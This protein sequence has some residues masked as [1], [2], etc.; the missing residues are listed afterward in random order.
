M[1]LVWNAVI[2]TC[3]HR[4]PFKIISCEMDIRVV[5]FGNDVL[6]YNIPL[7]LLTFSKVSWVKPPSKCWSSYVGRALRTSPP[8]LRRLRIVVW[9]GW[10]CRWWH[11][12]TDSEWRMHRVGW[13]SQST[14]GWNSFH[15]NPV[16]HQSKR[17]KLFFFF[18][19]SFYKAW[20]IGV[21]T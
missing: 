10:S 1:S 9:D 14:F 21:Y 5:F 16:V 2:S 11:Q 13:K 12:W 6:T 7:V 17:F 4:R 15:G 3:C 18:I 19:M 20:L 8:R